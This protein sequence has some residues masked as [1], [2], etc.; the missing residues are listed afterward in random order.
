MK[1]VLLSI[2]MVAAVALL[3][4]CA[5]CTGTSTDTSVA[6]SGDTANVYY[7]MYVDGKE[8]QSNVGSTPFTFVIDGGGVITGFNTA[9]KGMKVGETKK[10]TI[11]PAEGYG[12]KST[13][14]KQTLSLKEYEENLGKTLNVGDEFTVYA[15]T[16]SG[17]IKL[18][19]TVLSIN[20]DTDALE[21]SLNQELAGKTLV[22]E[23]TL[24]SIKSA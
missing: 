15:S 13:E 16:G 1:K 2:A 9:V 12:E 10:V 8:Y 17:I 23:I 11:P 7:T 18:M 5:G 20:K 4:I 19:A 14:N 21:V 3:V 24:D 22:Y 6:K